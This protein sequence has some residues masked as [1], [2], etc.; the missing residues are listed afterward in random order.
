MLPY[1]RKEL[2]LYSALVGYFLTVG[3]NYVCRSVIP[4]NTWYATV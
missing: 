1:I 4:Y 2:R 3:L